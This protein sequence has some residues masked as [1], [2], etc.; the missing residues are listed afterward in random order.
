MSSMYVFN[1]SGFSWRE[2]LGSHGENGVK[3]DRTER[4][5]GDKREG[6]GSQDLY[7]PSTGLWCLERFVELITFIICFNEY[8]H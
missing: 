7:I 5:V 4:T 2:C 3:T 8:V 1:L 6:W